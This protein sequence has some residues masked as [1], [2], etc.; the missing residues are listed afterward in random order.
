M[1]L[2]K[3]I[4]FRNVKLD[5]FSFSFSKVLKCV[6]QGKILL[7]LFVFVGEIHLDI[8]TQVLGLISLDEMIHSEKTQISFA[9]S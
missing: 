2:T 4:K 7:R 1:K 9:S 5:M 6:P 3:R 8:P